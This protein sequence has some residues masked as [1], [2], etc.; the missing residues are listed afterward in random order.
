MTSRVPSSSPWPARWQEAWDASQPALDSIRGSLSSHDAPS[1]RPLRV[2]QMD[3]ELLDQQLVHLLCEPLQRALGIA[4]AAL[5]TRFE[6]ELTLLVQV[7]LYKFSVWNLGATY[8]AKL[9]GLSYSAPIDAKGQLAP[10]GLRQRTLIMHGALT[11]LL[12]YC[13]NRLRTG[14]L[15]RAWPDAPSS[16]KRRI[17]WKTLAHLETTHA[18]AALL[19]T[20][21]FLWNGRYRSLADRLLNLSLVSTRSKITREVSYEFMNRQMVWHA[22]TEF[23]LFLVPLISP[24]TLQRRFAKLLSRLTSAVLPSSSDYKV[25]QRKRGKYETLPADQCAICAENASYT[26]GLGYSNT[27]TTLAP[28]SS[29]QESI[30]HPAS[31]D[32]VP[33]FPIYTPYITSCGHLYCYYCISERMMRT[34]DEGSET[35]W[36][37]LRCAEHVRSAD[38]WE[39]EVSVA[40]DS[41]SGS[42][43]EFSSEFGNTDLS[44]SVSSYL[45]SLTE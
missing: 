43:Y 40:R 20:M 2:N 36:E 29:A 22:F 16:D 39:A 3:S 14:A 13:Y 12:P 15:S 37:C 4:N 34:A 9:Q 21:V 26:L 7:V 1:P 33:A 23:L 42:D 17:A 28:Y 6:P 32:E 35:G 38:R 5:K 18:L 10:S 31:V 25:Q 44:G 45:G 8:G 27:L 11:I 30:S 41:A 24:R 19:N